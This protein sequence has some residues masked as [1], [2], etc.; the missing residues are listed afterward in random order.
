M[1]YGFNENDR[2]HGVDP[3]LQRFIQAETEKQRIQV[4]SKDLSSSG[5]GFHLL[6]GL[7]LLQGVIH[8]LTEKCWDTCMDKPSNKLDSKTQDCM[9]SCV[10]RFIDANILVTRRMDQ[11]GQQLLSAAAQNSEEFQ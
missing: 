6:F 3:A 2:A 7:L 10:H 1:S 4:L 8:D 5:K 11:K 9:R